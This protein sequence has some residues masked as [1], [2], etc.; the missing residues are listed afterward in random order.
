[1]THQP[2]ISFSISF[3]HPFNRAGGRTSDVLQE[4]KTKWKLLLA[5]IVLGG[6]AVLILATSFNEAYR[7]KRS[8]PE[9]RSYPSHRI[10]PFFSLWDLVVV[11]GDF[12]PPIDYAAVS[13]RSASNPVNISQLL[14]FRVQYITIFDSDITG[15]ESLLRDPHRG[16]PIMMSNPRFLNASPEDL[17]I[18]DKQKVYDEVTGNYV[19]WFGNA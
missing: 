4:M 8:F 11:P 17:I 12:V 18:I 7:I 3:Q 6:V 2:A 5:L 14:E 9:A 1:M 13:I 16:I 15:Y 19:Y 10:S